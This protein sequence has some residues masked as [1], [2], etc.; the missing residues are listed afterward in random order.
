M[1]INSLSLLEYKNPNTGSP[2]PD[3]PLPH[4]QVRYKNTPTA[5]ALKPLGNINAH[6]TK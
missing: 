1:T 3:S 2:L 4:S 5:V 6:F